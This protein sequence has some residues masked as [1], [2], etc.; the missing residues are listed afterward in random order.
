MHASRSAIVI[1]NPVSPVLGTKAER[2]AALR[3][4]ARGADTDEAWT[5]R[6]EA[7]RVQLD[8]AAAYDVVM[9][10]LM[11]QSGIGY[12][13]ETRPRAFEQHERIIRDS[14]IIG[15]FP[16]GAERS[17]IYASAAVLFEDEIVTVGDRIRPTLLGPI[18]ETFGP[19]SE[20]IAL[21][22]F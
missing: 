12:V 5:L 10:T 18:V 15:A 16:W 14:R 19:D 7:A 2:I 13:R 8:Q 6:S 3:E 21:A 4:L 11:R 9:Q 1:P 22:G 20:W 17:V